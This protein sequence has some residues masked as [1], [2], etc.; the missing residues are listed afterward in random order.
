MSASRDRLV[1]AATELFIGSSFHKV[2]IAEICS[3]ADV[4]KGTFYHFFPSKIELLLE[5]LDGYVKNAS[6]KYREI[7]ATDD[8]ARRKLMNIFA[9]QQQHNETWKSLYGATSGCVLGTIILEL[10]AGDAVVR[11]KAQWGIDEWTNAVRPIVEQ[12]F[13]EEKIDHLDA[14]SGAHILIG[15][16]QGAHVM[17]KVTNDPGVFTVYGQLAIEMLTGARLSK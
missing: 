5:V 14:A 6:E 11:R 7:A 4:N 10:A 9:I 12:F 8:N 17:A 1:N 16:I 3:A 2:G 13:R 15:F